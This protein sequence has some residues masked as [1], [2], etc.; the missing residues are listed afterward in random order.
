[1]SAL[2]DEPAQPAVSKRSKISLGVVNAFDMA[3][4]I[5]L[6]MILVRALNENDFAA[7]R[8]LW[9]LAGTSLN[10]FALAVPASLFYFL[11][12]NAQA[13]RSVYLLQAFYYML[14]AALVSVMTSWT[15]ARLNGFPWYEQAQIAG[16]V[17]LWVFSSLLDSMFNAQQRIA[18]QAAINLAFALLRL[19]AVVGVA[20]VYRS[21]S[22]VLIA[23]LLFGAAKAA[24]C[25]SSVLN[26]L[27]A[28]TRP[29]SARWREQ[30][31]FALP[32][33]VSTALSLLRQRIDQWMVASVFSAA[34]FGLYSV[35][36]VFSPIQ[37]LIRSTIN[38]LVLP[39]LNRL[40]A[41]ANMTSMLALNHRGNIAVALI[42][43]PSLFFIAAWATQLL[44]LLFTANYS[45][46][47]PAAQAYCVALLIDSM[48]VVT[49]LIVMRQG[50]FM[51]YWDAILMVVTVIGSLAGAYWFGLPGAALG[52][53]LGSLLAQIGTYYWFRKLSKVPLRKIQPWGTLA[54]IA[55]AALFA[56]VVSRAVVWFGN[57]ESVLLCLTVGALVFV[58][59]YNLA[60]RLAGLAPKI[61]EIF[62]A[63][64][65]RLA[66]FW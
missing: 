6:P 1:M 49:L 21:W 23:H 52:Q 4:Q 2:L 11:P 66:G 16:F 61:S 3:I 48:E 9:L 29:S 46:A 18:R 28:G 32:F 53:V 59:A 25:A 37:G 43:F 31:R 20:W 27:A 45:A 5:V 57:I 56:A 19:A 63:K 36:S 50:M 54:R 41:S 13:L 47:S 35:A 34:Q 40:E 7:Y 51:M 60:L 26:E 64:L 17:A 44:T 65:S 55:A 12:R 38:Q 30:F 24:V 15:W 42:M 14:A 62:G 58:L 33:G 39:E 8:G 22:A 10:V